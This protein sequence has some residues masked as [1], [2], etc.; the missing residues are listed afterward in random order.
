MSVSNQQ[1]YNKLIDIF[2][3]IA[4]SPDMKHKMINSFGSGP[5]YNS[6][7]SNYLFPMLWVEPGPITAVKNSSQSNSVGAWLYNFKFFVLDKIHK[8]DGNFNELMSDCNFILSGLIAHFDKHI[9]WNELQISIDGNVIQEPM[10]EITDDNLNGWMAD[11]TFKI[12]NKL[13]VCNTPF[14]PLLSFTVSTSSGQTAYRLIGP[15][16]P[17]GAQGPAGSGGSGAGATGS[18]GPQGQEGPQG[19]QGNQG[20]I[21]P[22]GYQGSTGATGAGGALGYYGVFN[23]TSNQTITSTTQ[24]YTASIT[25]TGISNGIVCDGID[26]ITFNHSGIYNLH[27]SAQLA[28]TD[29]SDHNANVWLR[30]NGVDIDFTNGQVTV[31]SRHGSTDGA[32]IASWNHILDLTAGDYVNIMWQA[33]NTSV[34]L[35]TIPAGT[36]PVTPITPSIELTAQQVMYTQLG[37]QG[38]Q[39]PAGTGTSYGFSTGLTVSGNTVSVDTSVIATVADLNNH[40]TNG[41]DSF[42]AT[43]TL[44]TLDNRNMQF[45]LNN[46]LV[47]RFLTQSLNTTNGPGPNV[48]AIFGNTASIAS[49]PGPTGSSV[50]IQGISAQASNTSLLTTFNSGAG[51]GTNR[52]HIRMI[53]SAGQGNFIGMIDNA[54]SMIFGNNSSLF[55]TL[56]SGASI[57]NSSASGAA[58]NSITV[59]AAHANTTGTSVALL[60]NNTGSNSGGGGVSSFRINNTQTLSG[61]GSQLLIDAQRNS[62]SVFRVDMSGAISAGTVSNATQSLWKLGKIISTGSTVDISRILEVNVDGINYKLVIAL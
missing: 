6:D 21:G 60:V 34:F 17:V 50:W 39:G 54:Q 2:Y 36:T 53:N 4:M 22:Q 5:T 37:P 62:N 55:L 44:G 35:D 19:A 7:I 27:F 51:G 61:T 16:G 31:P 24:A 8:G 11:I 10:F 9:Y 59:Q 47:A 56:N 29:A 33:E 58:Q 20:S 14:V 12:P 46:T 26:K 43:A 57:L 38:N 15:Q 42:G 25:N 52:P 23:S 41:G 1:T 30:K 48:F 40:F 49:I 32:I 18:Q 13:S 45:I 28:N 3:S